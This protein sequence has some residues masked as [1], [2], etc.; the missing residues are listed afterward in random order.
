MAASR[1]PRSLSFYSTFP[2]PKENLSERLRS[3]YANETP[4]TTI[5]ALLTTMSYPGAE[6]MRCLRSSS[7]SRRRASTATAAPLAA[8]ASAVASPMPLLAP[9]T[10]ATVGPCGSAARPASQR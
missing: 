5:P 9:V 7:R 2:F 8:R 1:C 6:A 3:D 10:R 4:M